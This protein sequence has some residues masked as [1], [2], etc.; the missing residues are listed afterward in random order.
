MASQVLQVPRLHQDF[1]LHHCLRRTWFR[2]LLQNLL[3]QE[4]GPS[5][6]RF[7]LWL[8]LPSDRRLNV[9]DR[10]RKRKLFLHNVIKSCVFIKN[11]I[12]TYSEDEISASRPFYNPDT[13][14]IKAPK[15]QGCPRCGGMVF[16]AEQQLA[17]GTVSFAT[18]THW[19]FLQLNMFT[20]HRA[21]TRTFNLFTDV[22]QEMFQLRRV[23]PTS[24]FNVSLRRPRQ[25]DSLP[26][27]LRQA[28]WT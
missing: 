25:G 20:V 21:L 17:K 2:R 4:M 8:R 3:R 26:C 15:G 16:A 23:P 18:A 19:V 10:I 28:L 14:S 12:S 7:C 9:S 11:I 13:T 1:G 5:R 22:A 24:G 27:L 6:L